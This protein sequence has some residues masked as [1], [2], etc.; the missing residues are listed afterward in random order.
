MSKPKRIL[1][2]PINAAKPLRVSQTNDLNFCNTNDVFLFFDIMRCFRLSGKSVAEETILL[3]FESQRQ[4]QMEAGF[5]RIGAMRCESKC[6]SVARAL[7]IFSAKFSASA[8]GP[9]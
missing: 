2:H 9:R 7:P 1:K 6:S 4:E 5:R 8:L 3:A